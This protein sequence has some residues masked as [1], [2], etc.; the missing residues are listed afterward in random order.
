MWDKPEIPNLGRVIGNQLDAL[1]YA[2]DQKR[3]FSWGSGGE[4]HLKRTLKKPNDWILAEIDQRKEQIKQKQEEIRRLQNEIN[5][6]FNY[7]E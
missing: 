5:D 7:G 2:L 3:F 1:H 4:I 6:L